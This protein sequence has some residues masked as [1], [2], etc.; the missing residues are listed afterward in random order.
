MAGQPQGSKIT[1]DHDIVKRWV[2]EREGKPSF[3]INPDDNEPVGLA[4][5]FEGEKNYQEK[6]EKTSP[7]R[8]FSSGERFHPFPEP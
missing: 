7:F 6:I 1:T 8:L 5:I 4:I 3:I 2:E